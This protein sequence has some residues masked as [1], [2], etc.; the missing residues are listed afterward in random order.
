MTNT[1]H[2]HQIK[3]VL[4]DWDMTL[5]AVLGDVPAVERTSALLQHVGLSYNHNAIEAARKE[6][7]ARIEA[8]RLPG[9]LAPQTKEG[10]ILYYQQLLELLGHPE[11]LPEVAEQIYDAYAHLPFIFYPDTLPALHRLA[12]RG[13][14][15]GVITN[16]SPL[17]RPVIET[18]LAEFVRPEHILISGELELYKPDRAIFIKGAASLATPAGQCLYTGDNLEVDAVGAV[19]AGGYGCGLWCDRSGRTTPA[20]LPPSV[21]HIT[22]LSQILKWLDGK[23]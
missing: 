18:R 15:L 21:H 17:I 23:P 16:H 20:I 5:G 14:G 9:P 13:V 10:L 6:R 4:F 3:T 19:Q 22:Q 11:A 2:N 12:A 8:G 7:Q 1:N